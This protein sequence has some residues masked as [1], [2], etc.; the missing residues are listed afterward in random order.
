MKL[1]TVSGR[2]LPRADSFLV[3][4][5]FAANSR[6][7]CLWTHRFTTENAPLQCQSHVRALLDISH[8]LAQLLLKL[9]I[10]GELRTRLLRHLGDSQ[11]VGVGVEC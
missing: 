5:I 10:V 4:I 8:L 7:V 2:V 6:P 1:L 11:V 3:L 9:I